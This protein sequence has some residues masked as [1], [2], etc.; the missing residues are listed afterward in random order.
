MQTS[1]RIS[2]SAAPDSCGRI[3]EV[4]ACRRKTEAAHLRRRP[5]SIEK[6]GAFCG[7]A[8]LL[9]RTDSFFDGYK[10]SGSGTGTFLGVASDGSA[11]RGFR[12]P[13]QASPCKADFRS[14]LA[15]PRTE[16]N[17]SAGNGRH[18]R[19]R[20]RILR[21]CDRRIPK[22]RFPNPVI[23]KTQTSAGLKK[24]RTNRKEIIFFCI[25]FA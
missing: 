14:G 9:R 20:K 7:R 19:N 5:A 12:K 15:D 4:G 17:L 10:S 13:D 23:L 25:R 1:E 22:F 16:N 8:F 18:C 21:G 24:R 3:A 6:S 11:W 2:G